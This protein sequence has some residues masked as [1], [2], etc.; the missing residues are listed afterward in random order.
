EVRKVFDETLRNQSK[1]MMTQMTSPMFTPDMMFQILAE[2]LEG[3]SADRVR[4]VDEILAEL[5]DFVGMT[6]VKEVIRR[7]AI[8]VT[9][10]QERAKM[11]IGSAEDMPS[12]NV[13]LTGNPG[14]GK[15]SVARKLGQVLQG[16]GVLLTSKVVEVDRSMLVGKYQGE[17]PK[18]VNSYIEQAMGGI[19]FI[20]EAYTLSQNGDQYG[21]E[22]ID[23]L[24]K[25]MED[26]A[27]KFVVIAAGYQHEMEAFMM[28][29]PGLSSRFNYRLHIDDYSASEL[30][31][32]F[33]RMAAKSEYTLTPDAEVKLFQTVMEMYQNRGTQFGNA[34]TIRNLF[35]RTVQCVSVRYS[36]M[37]PAMR[38]SETFGTILPEDIPSAD[39]ID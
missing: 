27:G 20:D 36:E 28:T 11:G 5:D 13:V 19:L 8:Q 12:M 29:N 6:E 4:P 39:S 30:V 23:T 7:L 1:R 34:R 26:D 2:D 21:I 22:A 37:N 24:M 10:L 33:K 17:T 14:T 16:M 25:R 32:I 38:S 3:Q 31:E 18:L 35:S 9:F 15:T